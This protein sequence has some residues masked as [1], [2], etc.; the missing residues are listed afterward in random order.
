[1]LYEDYDSFRRA[2]LC[3]ND[4]PVGAEAY[5]DN[6][7]NTEPIYIVW[8]NMELNVRLAFA[9]KMFLV[10]DVPGMPNTLVIQRL[11]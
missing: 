4:L 8:L 1:M 9:G 6:V 2:L 10:D 3:A 5:I 7:K 11:Q